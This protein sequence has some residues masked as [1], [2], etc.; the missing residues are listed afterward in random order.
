MFSTFTQWVDQLLKAAGHKY[1]KRI[2]YASGGKTRYR[3]IY[4]LTHMTGGKHVLDPDHMVVGAAF[5]LEPSAGK[6]V[7]AHITKVDGDMVTYRLDDGPQKGE[8]VTESKAALAKK[9]NEKH[10]V[11]AAISAERDKQSKVVADLK[12]AGASTKQVAREQA[13]LDR[14]EAALPAPPPEP[15]SEE[16]KKRAAKKPKSAE[17]KS[18]EPKGEGSA[19]A[20]FDTRDA[21]DIFNGLYNLS[22]ISLDRET[23]AFA[24]AVEGV[25]TVK[26]TLDH[27]SPDTGELEPREFAVLEQFNTPDYAVYVEDNAI[28]VIAKTGDMKGMTD[29]LVDRLDSVDRKVM[30]YMLVNDSNMVQAFADARDLADL[31]KFRRRV[32]DI[33]TSKDLREVR[34]KYK[35]APA[36]DTRRQ[37]AA[38]VRLANTNIEQPSEG[39]VQKTTAEFASEAAIP[40]S[41]QSALNRFVSKDKTR[42]NILAPFRLGEHLYATD[43]HRIIRVGVQSTPDKEYDLELPAALFASAQVNRPTVTLDADTAKSIA[44]VCQALGFAVPVEISTE[45]GKTTFSAGGRTFATV[46]AHEERAP[47]QYVDA[48]YLADMLS[49]EQPVTILQHPE[50]QLRRALSAHTASTQQLL[51]PRQF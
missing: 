18:A 20:F 6:E 42:A 13:R 37:M 8:T 1:I 51:M 30:P 10:G 26:Q 14:L 34:D 46:G 24:Y 7:H 22:H 38:A 5:Q 28:R 16:P 25:K 23:L 43:G 17:P 47:K 49:V 2:P 15:K 48:K 29:V 33:S 27:S 45:D 4:K 19:M 32:L 40:K 50:A 3:Y 11:H 41:L 36:A 12:A 31:G 21:R 39:R 9:L 35:R 44:A